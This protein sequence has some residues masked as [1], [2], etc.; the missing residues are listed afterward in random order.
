MRVKIPFLA[1]SEE[2]TSI[3]DILGKKWGDGQLVS[4][5]FTIKKWVGE[6]EV[7]CKNE[8][9]KWLNEYLVEDEEKEILLV[10][11]GKREGQ[12]VLKPQEQVFGRYVKVR[13]I[14]GVFSLQTDVIS[15]MR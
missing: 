1:P 15:S 12:L 10:V 6:R 8:K 9:K 2:I 11:W 3:E 7:E 13:N 4:L 14:G 5:P